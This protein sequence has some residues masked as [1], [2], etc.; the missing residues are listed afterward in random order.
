MHQDIYI[1]IITPSL[2]RADYIT[3]AIDSVERQDYQFIEHIIMDGGSTDGTLEL[4]GP[5]K[6]LRVISQ[7]DDGLYDAINKGVLFGHG[8]I[9]GFLNTDDYY[10]PNI[11]GLVAQTFRENPNIK[12]I[13]GDAIIFRDLPSGRR[14]IIERFS[15]HQ[16]SGLLAE[17]TLGTPM[18]NAWFFQKSV[19]EELGGF[20][21][22]YSISADRDFMIRFALKG[23][24]YTPLDQTIYYYRQHEESLTITGKNQKTSLDLLEDCIIAEDCLSTKSD[25]APRRNVF[26]VWHAQVVSDLVITALRKPDPGMARNYTIRGLSYN[27]LW[28][29]HFIYRTLWRT[30]RYINTRVQRFFHRFLPA[31]QA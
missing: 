1:S 2:N 11:F 9:L 7:P 27:S 21:T 19:F 31:G 13:T 5:Y 16:T 26:K 29:L 18:I 25:D 10:S 17:V 8:E 24:H 15:H 30:R 20:D 6:H 23:F 14:T 12:A 4:L 3:E 28:P 22:R